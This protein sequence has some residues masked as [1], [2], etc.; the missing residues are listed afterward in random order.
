MGQISVLIWGAVGDGMEEEGEPR[1]E[2]ALESSK[3]KGRR[4]CIEST[5]KFV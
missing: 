2:P 5:Q 4:N 3:A 1:E